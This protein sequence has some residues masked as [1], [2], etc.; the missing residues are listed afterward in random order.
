MKRRLFPYLA[1]LLLGFCPAL[2][3]SAPAGSID[4]PTV[5]LTSIGHKC[6]STCWC[7]TALSGL[8]HAD[9]PTSTSTFA[10]LLKGSYADWTVSYG[11]SLPGTFH[12]T[13]Y[14][15]HLCDPYTLPA[16]WAWGDPIPPR[17][18]GVH[19]A[20]G[21]E[22]EMWFEPDLT[23]PVFDFGD[24]KLDLH[25]IQRFEDWGGYC[26]YTTAPHDVIDCTAGPYYFDPAEET[27]ISGKRTET[28]WYLDAPQA[29]C[30]FH[31]HSCPGAHCP[32]NCKWG[33]NVWTYLAI[34]TAGATGTGTM[35]VYDG[36]S[37]GFTAECKYIPAPGAV[38]LCGIGIAVVGCLRRRRVL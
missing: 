14:D 21:A 12:V 19:C 37:W 2:Q 7:S 36:V 27:S 20:H 11:G 22:L 17:M 1:V 31:G 25:W 33:A 23:D 18:S 30:W 9:A 28:Y 5:M 16:T 13:T 8:K 6:G 10:T 15:A 26:G 29:G 3:L 38:L 32:G 24:P 34:G 35:T 4:T